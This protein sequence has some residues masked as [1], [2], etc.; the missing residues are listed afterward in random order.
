MTL[1]QLRYFIEVIDAGS[2]TAAADALF[3][4]QPS[5]TAAIQNL[6]KALGIKLFIRT[7]KG[8]VLTE[9][10]TDF[11]VHARQLL[12]EADM[13]SLRYKDEY[14]S[15]NHFTVSS[16]HLN[17]A[18]KAFTNIIPRELDGT[19]SFHILE[20]TTREVID[21]VAS[22]RSEIGVL[23]ITEFSSSFLQKLFKR[24]ELEFTELLQ[25][26]V[27]VYVKAGHP[28]SDRDMVTAEDLQPYPHMIYDQG[29]DNTLYLSE[30]SIRLLNHPRQIHVRDRG[31]AYQLMNTFDAFASDAGTE[32]PDQ[33]DYKAL[34]LEPLEYY[35]IGYITRKNV[36]HNALTLAYIEELKRLAEEVRS[37]Q[38]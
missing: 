7:N 32:N 36:T 33:P 26:P 22:L 15:E 2:I 12:L 23:S 34:R 6:E 24:N 28:L 27:C 37:Y 35:H 5:L 31:T 3:I 4:S 30:S 8:V 14:P 1:Q 18:V 25:V 29:T 38:K 17:F 11:A 20:T 21:N 16:Q 19:Y 9:E 10:G 13:L